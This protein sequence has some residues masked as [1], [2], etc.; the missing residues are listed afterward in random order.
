MAIYLVLHTT[1]LTV[2]LALYND[3]ACLGFVQHDKK[4]ASKKIIS[5]IHQILEQNNTPLD[6]IDFFATHQG[7]GPFTT[8][9]ILIATANGLSFATGTPIV[10]VNGLTTFVH[11]HAQDD[12]AT[13]ALL[14]AYTGQAYYAILKSREQEPIIGCAPIATALTLIKEQCKTSAPYL[15]GNGVKVFSS[16]VAAL[17]PQ[18]IIAD[19]LP[20]SCSVHALA[21]QGLKQWSNKEG[22][23]QQLVPLYMKEHYAQRPN[24]S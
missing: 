15:V 10:G 3:T 20:D 2:D 7:P 19:D 23:T 12:R 8:L 5:L 1:Y 24:Q 21:L 6:S 11:E 18:A 9:R 14:N 16:E 13:V 17:L 22:I 4:T